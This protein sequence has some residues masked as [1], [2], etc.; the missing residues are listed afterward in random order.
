MLA[1]IWTRHGLLEEDG[2]II[3]VGTWDDMNMN[4]TCCMRLCMRHVNTGNH[5]VKWHPARSRSDLTPCNQIIP[6]SPACMIRLMRATET[7]S[8]FRFCLEAVILSATAREDVYFLVPPI[9]GPET[10]RFPFCFSISLNTWPL[11]FL[12]K[13][14]WSLISLPQVPDL[15][16][17]LQK[18]KAW[19]EGCFLLWQGW[20][21]QGWVRHWTVLSLQE[22]TFSSASLISKGSRFWLLELEILY[23]MQAQMECAEKY[24][25]WLEVSLPLGS[26]T[27]DF[28]YW[29]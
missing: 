17:I 28:D 18:Q 4:G 5:R 19:L 7:W 29:K 15:F 8:W 26:K 9:L 24:C 16:S 13:S 20:T 25:H 22:G 1:W 3:W 27:A 23:Y 2:S 21:A 10:A 14:S 11:L 6:I 12:S